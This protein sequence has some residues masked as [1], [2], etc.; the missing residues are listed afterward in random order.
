MRH[1]FNLGK[2]KEENEKIEE[3]NREKAFRKYTAIVKKIF[4]FFFN[5]IF[6]SIGIE[7]KKKNYIEK[8]KRI[9]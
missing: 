7:K 9:R 6:F 4:L 2:L 5:I 8:K 1:T 3:E